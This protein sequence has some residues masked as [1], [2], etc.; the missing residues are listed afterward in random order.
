MSEGV[1]E[2]N[3]NDISFDYPAESL[4]WVF[5]LAKEAETDLN[6]LPESAQPFWFR[7]NAHELNFSD[8]PKQSA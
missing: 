6:G 7:I 2:T 4:R 5:D 1:P 8:S 3:G